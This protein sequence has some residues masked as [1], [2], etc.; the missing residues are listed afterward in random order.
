MSSKRHTKSKQKR[1][2][3]SPEETQEKY[4]LRTFRM[5]SSIAAARRKTPMRNRWTA[6]ATST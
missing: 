1:G 4:Q 6:L 3:M 5:S 2:A